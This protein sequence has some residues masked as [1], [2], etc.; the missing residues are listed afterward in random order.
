MQLFT[1]PPSSRMQQVII[2]DDVPVYRVGDGRFFIDDVL[3]E[4]G[5]VIILESEPNPDLEPLNK[6]AVDAMTAYLKKLDDE[7]KKWANKNQ[8]A[9]VSQ[10][11]AFTNRHK[12]KQKSKRGAIVLTDTEVPILGGRN[13]PSEPKA[14]TIQ[15]EAA[16]VVEPIVVGDKAA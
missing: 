11:D 12:P 13:R 7:G 4:K 2:P 15:P 9:Y 1:T 10:L 3:H 5:T 16:S 8:K 6:M 14:T